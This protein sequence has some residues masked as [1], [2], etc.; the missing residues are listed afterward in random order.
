LLRILRAVALGAVLFA[1]LTLA[2]TLLVWWHGPKPAAAD[3]EAPAEPR[4]ASAALRPPNEADRQ[5]QQG[6]D[7]ARSGGI[8]SHAECAARFEHLVRL[9]CSRFVTEQKTFPAAVKQGDWGGG[10][11]TAQCEAE[12]NAYWAPRVQDLREQ[13]QHHAAQTRQLRQWTPELRQ[14]RNYDAV[15]GG[16]AAQPGTPWPESPASATPPAPPPK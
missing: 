11:T 12:V 16:S 9:G 13:G 10:K 2:P 4:A 1:L 3:A 8:A 15:R 7:A 14:C 5:V 6:F